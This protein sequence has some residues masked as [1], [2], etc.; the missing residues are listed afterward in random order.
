MDE[1]W[2]EQA[3]FSQIWFLAAI[4][5]FATL[6]RGSIV[7]IPAFGLA[8]RLLVFRLIG[9]PHR[10]AMAVAR[11]ACGACVVH[12]LVGPVLL[13]GHWDKW[14]RTQK[15]RTWHASTLLGID[16]NRAIARGIVA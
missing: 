15:A 3:I 2:S 14:E 8:R 16:N 7:I 11:H 5:K 10:H 4:G 1:Q 12:G 13:Q 6:D 9:I